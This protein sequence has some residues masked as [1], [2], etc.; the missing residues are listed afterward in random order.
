MNA[1]VKVA[2]SAF[3]L[4]ALLACDG[5]S[6]GGAGMGGA[7]A[8]LEPLDLECTPSYSPTYDQIFTRRIVPTC[9]AGGTSCHG[10]SGN[11]GNLTLDPNDPDAAY[12][13]LLEAD[14][15]LVVPGDPECSVM[16]QRLE[17]DDLDFVMPVRQPLMPGEL[18]S[19]RKWV[20]N[21]AQR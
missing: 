5:S 18:C 12:S 15:G 19:I 9:G 3:M 6:Q 4:A 2:R 10:P 16:I 1:M 11:K 14:H 20:A 21:G 7:D 8:C 13:A 17:S